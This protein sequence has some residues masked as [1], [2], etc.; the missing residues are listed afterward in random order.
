MPN[1]QVNPNQYGDCRFDNFVNQYDNAIGQL[2]SNPND[3][4]SWQSDRRCRR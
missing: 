2:P 1:I 3:A 4:C